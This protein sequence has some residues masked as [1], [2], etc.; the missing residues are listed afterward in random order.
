MQKI[1]F[2]S[3]FVAALVLVA[4]GEDSASSKDDET[5]K[6][7]YTYETEKKLPNCSDEKEGMV[8]YVVDQEDTLVCK[9]TKWTNAGESDDDFSSCS[10]ESPESSSSENPESSSSEEPKSS[11]D[12]KESSS[13][14]S[15][16]S[17]DKPL[18][19]VK[20]EVIYIKTGDRFD[21]DASVN[22][23]W[24]GIDWFT[25]E[26]KDKAS[27]KTLET[28]TTKYDYTANG[29]SFKIGKESIYSLKGKEMNCIV[30]A[31]ETSTKASFSDTTVVR[32]MKNFPT[33]VITAADT[34]CLWSGDESVDDEAIY[35]YSP[36]WGGKNS[37]LGDFGN[38]DMQ[39]FRWKFS[40][41]DG[42]FYQGNADG[43]LDT[44]IA[45]FN[46]GF[47][48]KTREGSVTITLDFRD[49]ISE[50]PTQG[51][52]SGHRAKEVSHE[53]YFSKA[54]KNLG[55]DTV[56]T[57]TT[58]MVAPSFAIV[59]NI[60]IIAYAESGSK[61]IVSKL[62]NETWKSL[63]SVTTSTVK[64]LSVVAHGN[65]FYVGV[66]DNS[67]LTVYKSSSGTSNPAKVGSSISGVKDVKLVSNGSSNPHAVVINSNSKIEMYDI[68]SSLSKNSK[69]G[70][71]DNGSFTE[72][73]AIF[74]ESGLL[75]VVG[76]SSDYK[77]Y[78][79]YFKSDLSQIT[80]AAFNES[81]IGQAKIASSGSKIYMVYYSR[82][83]SSSKIAIGN[84]S[85]SSI[86]WAS[87]SIIRDGI[88]YN[89]SLVARNGVVYAAFDNRAAISQV[90]VYR[91]ENGKWHLHGENQLPY[92]S[93]VFYGQNNYYLRGLY[94]TFAFDKSGKL[95]LSML[96][97]ESSS[98]PGKNNGPLVMKYVADNWTIKDWSN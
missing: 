44:S 24:Q 15:T 47:I 38:K 77:V 34:V 12:S 43:S 83:S 85:N 29:K 70:S 53:V 26:C 17:T 72:V 19:W 95:Y 60:P 4:C 9:S 58:S 54:W 18:I 79:G 36:E 31:Q 67:G 22:N 27:G 39:D 42:N 59:N 91:Y 74:T 76:V 57:K 35:Y 80:K 51:F 66:I 55:K 69:F 21:L 32:P 41:V 3:L 56:I 11:N 88:I 87:G 37:A 50:N 13:S 5:T 73:D 1:R 14:E 25:W 40:N 30:S 96:A 81:G 78:Y 92:F 65:D 62:G 63:G 90:D 84:I 45:E 89:I 23:V 10:S 6:D 46:T 7:I 8:A 86:S 68:S 98:G 33:G 48:R 93:S 64:K 75:A 97:Q 71:M 20:D 82:E 28:K 49:S 94:P 16:E 2:A 61:V 52:Y